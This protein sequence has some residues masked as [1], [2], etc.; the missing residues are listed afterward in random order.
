MDKHRIA[1]ERWKEN[2]RSYYLLQKQALSARTS[3]KAHRREL[4]RAR[5]DALKAKRLALGIAPPQLGRP[6]RQAILSPPIENT[7]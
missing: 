4:Y 1:V 3:Y 6:K 2:N 5:R 7:Q